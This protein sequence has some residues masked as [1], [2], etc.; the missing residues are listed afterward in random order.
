M[1]KYIVSFVLF[2]SFTVA[3]G[4]Q[5]FDGG[6]KNNIGTTVLVNE[7]VLSDVD[8]YKTRI[9]L[10]NATGL[11]LGFNFNESVQIVGEG[12]YGFFR[13][14]F[15][16]EDNGETKWDKEISCM[17]IQVPI[18]FRYNKDNGS[19]L[20]FGPQY[21]INNR[22]RETN[23]AQAEI[24]ASTYYDKNYWAAIFSFGSYLMGW[25]NF[26]IASGIRLTYSFNDFISGQGGTANPDIFSYKAANYKPYKF[27]TPLSIGFVLEL[28]YDLGFMAK[29][30]CT[31]RR[32]FLFF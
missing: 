32:S 25:D 15:T 14:K 30:P 6:I 3:H 20:E 8:K 17:Q 27:T 4:Q 10:A 11:K 19:Y 21:T 18:L 22:I 12:Y 1:S 9:S 16:I 5:F 29:S 31:G 24:D 2:V 7:N 23:S 26:G 13:Q 28:N